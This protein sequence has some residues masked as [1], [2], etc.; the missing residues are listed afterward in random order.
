MFRIEQREQ[1]VL[2]VHLLMIEFRGEPLGGLQGFK[3]FLGQAIL[4][5]GWVSFLAGGIG[6]GVANNKDA[7]N[8]VPMTKQRCNSIHCKHF[9]RRT[10]IGSCATSDADSAK[11]TQKDQPE[12]QAR[13]T[14]FLAC[15]SGR[16]PSAPA[17]FRLTN[18]P[19]CAKNEARDIQ[20]HAADFRTMH[21]TPRRIVQV[22][23]I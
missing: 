4:V 23:T 14:F 3:R 11:T 17:E 12:A 13:K 6:I 5:H 19:A 8:R 21:S 7:A 16:C 22:G 10:G 18:R 2:D 15:A 9:P 1:E 20:P